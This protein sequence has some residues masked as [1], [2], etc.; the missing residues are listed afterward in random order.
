[1]STETLQRVF[2]TLS[3]TTRIRILALLEREELAVQEVMDVLG[4]AQSRVSRHLGIL[5]EAGLLEDRREGTHVF[6]RFRPPEEIEWKDAWALSRSALLRDPIAERDAGAMVR[7]IEARATRSRSFF[8]SVGP[9]WDALRKIFGDDALRARAISQLVPEGLVVADIGTGTGILATELATL[10]LRVV[11]IDHSPRMLEAARAKL[12]SAGIEGVELRG[13]EAHALPLD[14]AEVDAV[15]AHMV[16][17]Y[18]PSPAESIAEFARVIKPG[19]RV[20]IVDFVPHTAEWMRA[21]LGVLW[22]GFDPEEVEAWLADAGLRDIR[23]ER[24]PASA[25]TRELPATFLSRATRP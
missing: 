16:L 2:K 20:V 21:D 12:D 15:F 24:S 7:V 3:D 23:S 4:M 1:M 13:G 17:H 22:L 6:Y 5:R 10:G 9:E 25:S 11:G 8:D 14:D 18:L 19:G